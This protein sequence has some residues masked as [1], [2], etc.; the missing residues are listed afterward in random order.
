MRVYVVT[1]VEDGYRTKVHSVYEDVDDAKRC[2]SYL[3]LTRGWVTDVDSF[4]THQST[5]GRVLTDD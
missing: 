3:K 5:K 1:Y 4:D 2:A